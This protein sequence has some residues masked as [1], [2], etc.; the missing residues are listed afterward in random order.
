MTKAYNITL[1][2]AVVYMGPFI[3]MDRLQYRH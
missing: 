2:Y 1:K 3:Y